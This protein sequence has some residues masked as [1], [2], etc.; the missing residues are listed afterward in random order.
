M[1]L[2]VSGLPLYESA[3]KKE[4]NNK[5]TSSRN[6]EKYVFS[7]KLKIYKLCLMKSRFSDIDSNTM[8]LEKL[9]RMSSMEG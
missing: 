3:T 2:K 8:K 5:R 7:I 9:N 1:Y 4:K 6:R